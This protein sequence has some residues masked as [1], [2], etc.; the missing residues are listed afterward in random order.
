[1]YCYGTKPRY[2]ELFRFES[3]DA[4]AKHYHNNQ[5]FQHINKMF[6]Q[7]YRHNDW[8]KTS[9]NFTGGGSHSYFLGKIEDV[10]NHE[11]Q[12]VMVAPEI[13]DLVCRAK[14][15]SIAAVGSAIYVAVTRAKRDLIVPERLRDWL[16]EISAT[17]PKVQFCLS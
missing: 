12:V 16:E 5:G 1:M 10:R 14:P 15:E 6:D 9:S 13:V 8:L 4:V 7:G 2:G 3:W 17:Q 11:F